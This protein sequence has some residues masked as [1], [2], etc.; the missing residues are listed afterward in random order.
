[1]GEN[2]YC[3]AYTATSLAGKNLETEEEACVISHAV[4]DS[5]N[6]DAQTLALSAEG[7]NQIR[8]MLLSFN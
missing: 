7:W 3:R 6:M 5:E 8:V 1:M 2:A 4:M